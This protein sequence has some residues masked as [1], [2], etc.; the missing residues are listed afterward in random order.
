MEQVRVGDTVKAL[1]SHCYKGREGVVES[2]EDV[3]GTLYPHVRLNG[4]GEKI[5]MR[6]GQY[7]VTKRGMAD[8]QP[9]TLMDEIQPVL[10]RI[11]NNKHYSFDV[12][13]SVLAEVSNLCE[14]MIEDLER[15]RES[16]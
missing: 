13:E 14:D 7:A 5:I 3:E 9:K 10:E 12:R 16:S 4:T 15:E 2:M 6:E 8:S 11:R 1:G